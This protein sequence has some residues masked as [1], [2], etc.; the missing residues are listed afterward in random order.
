MPLVTLRASLERGSAPLFFQEF[1][2]FHGRHAAGAGSGDRLTVAAVLHVA[3]SI[4]SGHAGENVS[5]GNEIAGFSGVELGVERRG[6]GN[7][8]EAEGHGGAG[9]T[10]EVAGLH[11]S[12]I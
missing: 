1:L 2:R 7:L 10:P 8:P 4:D 12:A 3:A 5:A 6:M 9:K 11:S